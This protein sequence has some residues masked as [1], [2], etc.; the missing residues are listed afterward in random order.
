MIE[1]ILLGILIVVLLGLLMWVKE[2]AGIVK[3]V[4][5]RGYTTEQL[6]RARCT[7]CGCIDT[8]TPYNG[9]MLE[10]NLNGAAAT[11]CIVCGSIILNNRD[12]KQ[13]VQALNNEA[14]MHNFIYRK[15]GALVSDSNI[16]YDLDDNT[17]SS[18]LS[19]AN[20]IK[21]NKDDM[22]ERYIESVVSRAKLSSYINIEDRV[23]SVIE[24]DFVDT[25]LTG[26]KSRETV[27]REKY[28]D[29]LSKVQSQG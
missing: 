8:S 22:M 1:S 10:L 2:I 15:V 27:M 29:I 17:L 24:K 13:D 19:W 9:M 6:A 20:D 28:E 11:K 21:I 3:A 14:Y 4:V 25:F 16:K 12:F 5:P 23:E 7:V 18:M 26:V